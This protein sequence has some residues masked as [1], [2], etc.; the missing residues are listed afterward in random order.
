MLHVSPNEENGQCQ[1]AFPSPANSVT[2]LYN[3]SRKKK[4]CLRCKS[5]KE[6]RSRDYRKDRVIIIP[7]DQGVYFLDY[8]SL[9]LQR[10]KKTL[11][12]NCYILELASIKNLHS[13]IFTHKKLKEIMLFSYLFQYLG[14]Q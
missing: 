3:F 6:S 4:A 1:Q 7:R 13:P 9:I 2:E 8:K 10:G 5:L 12:I 14:P 11:I